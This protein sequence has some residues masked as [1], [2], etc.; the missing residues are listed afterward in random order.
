MTIDRLFI[1]HPRSVGRTYL[2]HLREALTFGILMVAAGAAC[3]LHAL[4]PAL[5]PRTGSCA[6]SWL[7]ERMVLSRSRDA[8]AAVRRFSCEVD[9]PVR[10]FCAPQRASLSNSRGHLPHP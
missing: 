8:R 1:E 3:V 6:V 2:Q 4:V 5:F 10:R 7:Y 9:R